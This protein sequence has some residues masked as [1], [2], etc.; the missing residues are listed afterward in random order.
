[1]SQKCE[2]CKVTT[3]TLL[4]CSRCKVTYY[5]GRTCQ[6]ADWPV[7]KFGCREPPKNEAEARAD[8]ETKHIVDHHKEFREIIAKYGLDK[9]AD[10][11]SELLTSD[12]VDVSEFANKF[13]MSYD[14]ARAFLAFIDVGIKYKEEHLKSGGEELLGMLG[15]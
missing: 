6:R 5:C 13:G 1:M 11:I 7:H 14:E 9:Q 8:A 10:Y 12:G 3:V 15:Q 4:K 2:K